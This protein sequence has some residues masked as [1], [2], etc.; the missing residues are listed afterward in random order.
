M[1]TTEPNQA[2]QRTS[3]SLILYVRQKM[4]TKWLSLFII[5]LCLS[6]CAHVDDVTLRHPYRDNLL[7][8]FVTTRPYYLYDQGRIG[9]FVMNSPL[10]TFQV[11]SDGTQTPFAYPPNKVLPPQSKIRITEIGFSSTK[12]S[13]PH[14]ALIGWASPPDGPPIRIYLFHESLPIDLVRWQKVNGILSRPSPSD[15]VATAQA[16]TYHW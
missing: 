7:G 8:E 13:G 3:A 5:L 11:A 12:S 10:V 15:Y 1:K 9:Y 2:M 14:S 4:K 6:G 16:S